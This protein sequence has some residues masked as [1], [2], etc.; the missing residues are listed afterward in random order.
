MIDVVEILAGAGGIRARARDAC[1]PMMALLR[2]R[3]TEGNCWFLM[4]KVSGFLCS[5]LLPILAVVLK[6]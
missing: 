5:W 1:H 2:H 4:P 6:F 3:S